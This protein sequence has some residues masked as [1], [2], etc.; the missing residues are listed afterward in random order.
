MEL[1]RSLFL[2][3]AIFKQSEIQSENFGIMSIKEM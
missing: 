3:R 2:E 1:S